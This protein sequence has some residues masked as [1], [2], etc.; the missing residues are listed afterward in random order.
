MVA[1]LHH[2]SHP[3]LNA[4]VRVVS[5]KGQASKPIKERHNNDNA[6]NWKLATG[7]KKYIR[8]RDGTLSVS[9]Y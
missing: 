5:N 6:G 2:R 3:W 7:N 1:N 8:K 9:Y 4:T